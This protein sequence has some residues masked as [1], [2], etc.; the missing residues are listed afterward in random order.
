MKSLCITAGTL[1]NCVTMFRKRI[2]EQHWENTH[3]QHWQA[4][5]TLYSTTRLGDLAFFRHKRKSVN[6]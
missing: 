5:A 1:S 4:L 2:V 3:L 6:Y